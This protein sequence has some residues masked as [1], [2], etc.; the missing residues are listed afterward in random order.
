VSLLGEDRA[1][2]QCAILI[3]QAV[4][5]LEHHG[6]EADLLRAVARYVQERDR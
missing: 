1:R 6:Q 2:Q 4:E 3:G 5:H